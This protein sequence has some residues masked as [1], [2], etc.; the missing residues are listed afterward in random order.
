VQPL[1]GLLLLLYGPC[2]PLPVDRCPPAGWLWLGLWVWLAV[3]TAANC[4][5][6]DVD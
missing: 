6:L 4:L 2:C 1:L 3:A 5:P